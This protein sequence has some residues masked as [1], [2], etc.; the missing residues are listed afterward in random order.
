[1]IISAIITS[2]LHGVLVMC[3]VAHEEHASAVVH[4]GPYLKADTSDDY[5]KNLFDVEHGK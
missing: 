5:Q 2:L 3:F 4:P 1:M